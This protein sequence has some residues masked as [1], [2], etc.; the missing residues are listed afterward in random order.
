MYKINIMPQR[1]KTFFI[2]LLREHHATWDKRQHRKRWS[3]WL[4]LLGSFLSKNFQSQFINWQRMFLLSFF[5]NSNPGMRVWRIVYLGF[6]LFA[7]RKIFF[8]FLPSMEIKVI[9]LVPFFTITSWITL[10]KSKSVPYKVPSNLIIINGCTISLK[11][12]D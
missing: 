7:L 9:F 3:D 5:P 12:M 11:G 1:R 4:C 8:Y 2:C 10:S 6:I